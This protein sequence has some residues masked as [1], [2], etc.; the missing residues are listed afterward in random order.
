MIVMP[1][2][3]KAC[4]DASNIDSGFVRFAGRFRALVKS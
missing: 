2:L 1:Q 4:R 3:G